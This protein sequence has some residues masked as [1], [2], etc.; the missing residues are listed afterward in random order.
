MNQ[1]ER[2]YK[3]EQLLHTHRS[4]SSAQLQQALEVSRATLNRDI[5]YL[6]DRL[7]VPIRC[8][9]TQGGY[10]LDRKHCSQAELPGLW[11][12]SA[13]IHALLTMQ[14][15]L[16]NLDPGGILTPHVQPLIE[17]LNQ[18]LGAAN[19]PAEEVR[20]RVL[21]VGLGKRSIKLSHFERIGAALLRRHRLQIVYHGRGRN[22]VTE[23]EISPQRLVYYRENWY[24]DAWC[25]L[26]NELRSFAID[27]ITH[28]ELIDRPAHEIPRQNTETTLGPAYG[29][30][31]GEQRHWARLRFTP[32]RARWVSAEHWHP[33]QRGHTQP[34]GSYQLEIPYSDDRELL[35][36]ILKHGAEVEVLAPVELR[37][38]VKA[39]IAR[40][41][42]R[43]E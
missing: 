33:D 23:R 34:D 32:E 25:H 7:G 26:R 24:L 43:Y 9:K 8:D 35:M 41:G 39:E 1:T 38:R 27:A 13:E 16:A 36:D 6:R 3:I 37:E 17:R 22:E 5:A 31:A 4:L 18:L 12:S 14:H 42:R 15:L 10:T 2:F 20:R 29:I 21:V 28:V 11:F 40:M 30:F 19:N